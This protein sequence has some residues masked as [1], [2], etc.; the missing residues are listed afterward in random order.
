MRQL[1]KYKNYIFDCDG[2]LLDSNCLK[3][4]AMKKSLEKAG[5]KDSNVKSCIEY[6]SSNF[7]KSRYH[8]V[9]Y[10]FQYIIE[11]VPQS[12]LLQKKILGNYENSC[13]ILYLKAKKTAHIDDALKKLDGRKYVASGSE[14]TQLKKALSKKFPSK[15]F[16]GIFGSPMPKLEIVSNILENST[17]N[18]FVLIGD[19]LADLDVAIELK[20]DF[21]GYTP[22]SNTPQ[23]LMEKCMHHGFPT[24]NTW[25]I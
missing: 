1:S 12:E 17:N 8:H 2:V 16:S 24:L 22:Y 25:N 3:I 14:E 11:E 7:G 23:L 6:F 19:S 15:M 5:I 9:N 10:F 21:V 20:I 4:E 18:D 13:D